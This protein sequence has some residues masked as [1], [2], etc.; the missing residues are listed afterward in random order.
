MEKVETTR[1]I[2]RLRAAIC[3]AAI[4]VFGWSPAQAAVQLVGSWTGEIDFGTNGFS[5]APVSGCNRLALIVISAESTTNP[6][7]NIGSVTLG[8]QTL[9]SIESADGIVVGP[10]GTYH[11]L[12][13]VGYLVDSE[14]TSMVGSALSIPWDQAPNTPFGGFKIGCASPRC[15]W[16]GDCTGRDDVTGGAHADLR[17][18]TPE[19]PPDKTEL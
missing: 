6:V 17:A 16:L 18:A 4:C 3:L 15:V 12:L 14:I 5:Y 7:S 11:D 10:A 13:W 1:T 19:C 9:T 2:G 8:G